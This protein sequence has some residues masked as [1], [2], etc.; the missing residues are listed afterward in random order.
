M[1]GVDGDVLTSA[2]VYYIDQLVAQGKW[3]Q[4]WRESKRAAEVNTHLQGR[5]PIKLFGRATL[6]A[7]QPNLLR[8]I[9]SRHRTEQVIRGLA[10]HPVMA[11]GLAARVDLP[12]RL[13]RADALHADRSRQRGCDHRAYWL[14]F[15]LAGSEQ[16]AA[17]HGMEARHPWCDL[18][19]VELFQQ[20]PTDIKV[21]DGWTKWV[22]RRACEPA[23][24]PE[25][26]WHSGKEHLGSHLN[27]QVLQEAAPYLCQL[28]EG[29]RA[30]LTEF[31]R[32]E[33]VTE[34]IAALA[35]ADLADPEACDTTIVVTALAG[36]LR[37]ANERRQ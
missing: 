22:V 6:A 30:R 17:R 29:Q 24:G 32:D 25:V 15:S 7:L 35:Q 19:V 16:I 9:R 11:P 13:R 34:A 5:R 1:N 37:F 14:A 10:A 33:A 21:R 23:L 2:G 4:G 28:L 27:R 31:V 18:R 12:A 8:R 3:R 36:W 26:V 20:L